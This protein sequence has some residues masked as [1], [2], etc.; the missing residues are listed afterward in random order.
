MDRTETL[1]AMQAILIQIQ[2]AAQIVHHKRRFNVVS[3]LAN[4][5]SFLAT[6][7]KQSTH[8]YLFENRFLELCNASLYSWGAFCNDLSIGGPWFKTFKTKHINVLELTAAY[9]ALKALARNLSNAIIKLKIDNKA[10]I[11][12]VNNLGSPKSPNLTAVAQAVWSWA[13]DRD[14]TL[15]AE[16]LPGTET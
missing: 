8:E 1:N 15:I 2:R 16:H 12:A 5:N 10:A 4:R 14:L 7:F 13:M 3:V 9:W 11:A 6:Q